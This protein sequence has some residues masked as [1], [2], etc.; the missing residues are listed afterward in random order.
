M[1]NRT[2]TIDDIICL[3]IRRA[4]MVDQAE[5]QIHKIAENRSEFLLEMNEETFRKGLQELYK[6]LQTMRIAEGAAVE[7]YIQKLRNQDGSY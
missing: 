1:K 3:W 4:H 7:M 5:I 2:L 6:G